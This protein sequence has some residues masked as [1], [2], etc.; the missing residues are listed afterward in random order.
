V[1]AHSR[2]RC[3]FTPKAF[4]T[5]ARG[6]TPGKK[7][8]TRSNPERVEYDSA[9]LLSK[10]GKYKTAKSCLYIKKLADI[11]VGVLRKIVS[12]S[13]MLMTTSKRVKSG[14]QR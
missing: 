4:D 14:A 8:V 1:I 5:L 2:S 13:V 11:D 12:K 9:D 6:N 10:L 7:R 3:P